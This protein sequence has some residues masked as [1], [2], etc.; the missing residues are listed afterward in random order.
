[1]AYSLDPALKDRRPDMTIDASVYR[2]ALD[3]SK[4][5]PPR[6]SLSQL[7]RPAP[8]AAAGLLAITVLGLGL[9]RASGRGGVTVAG[10]WLDPVSERLQSV[11]ALKRFRHP[12]WALAATAATFLVGYFRRAAGPTE[13]VAYTTGVLVLAGAAMTARSA[14][15]RARGIAMSQASWLPGMVFGLVTGAIG[16]PVAP[17]PVVRTDGEDNPRLHL[18]APITLSA[19]SLMLFVESVWLHTPLTQAWAV[20][21]LIMSASMLLPV[22]PLDGAHLGKTGLVAGAGVVGGALLVGLGLI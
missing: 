21:A 1:M 13:V 9:A 10:Q 8:A 22:G 18:A 4:P 16:L 7:Q 17:L 3:L 12:G 15:A 11:P 2:T 20:A 5:L 14:L 19:L 6:W